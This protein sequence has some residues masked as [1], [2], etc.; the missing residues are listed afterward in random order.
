MIHQVIH[1]VILSKKYTNYAIYI[2]ILIHIEEKLKKYK[3]TVFK[4]KYQI[5]TNMLGNLY[6]GLNLNLDHPSQEF[7]DICIKKNDIDW[8]IVDN[9]L[10]QQLDFFV[11]ENYIHKK[12]LFESYKWDYD[13]ICLDIYKK[14]GLFDSLK[15]IGTRENDIIDQ[16]KKIFKKQLMTENDIINILLRYKDIHFTE[17][18][19]FKY[20]NFICYFD[21][22][23]STSI[24]KHIIKEYIF[25]KK[26]YLIKYIYEFDIVNEIFVEMLGGDYICSYNKSILLIKYVNSELIDFH[27]N[28]MIID[29]SEDICSLECDPSHGWSESN[30]ESLL[31]PNYITHLSLGWRYNMPINIPNSIKYFRTGCGFSQKIEIPDSVKYI[32]INGNYNNP[33]YFPDSVEYIVFSWNIC[34]SHDIILPKNI[35][36]LVYSG[37]NSSD[38]YSTIF[39]PNNIKELHI[40]NCYNNDIFQC[41]LCD[42]M[43]YGCSYNG[44]LVDIENSINKENEKN[45][46]KDIIHLIINKKSEIILPNENIKVYYDDILINITKKHAQIK[47]KNMQN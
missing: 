15:E 33:T 32:N 6:H 43:L 11:L 44:K 24:I 31:I 5:K 10:K 38:I 30:V 23:D 40:S 17:D 37:M 26:E 7:L 9:L 18:N 42:Y 3:Y 4:M 28:R 35:K 25:E 2:Y 14:F 41:R 27:H 45:K 16:F 12:K 8:I 21:Y 20:I 13:N 1:Q 19:V 29:K 22:N 34:M 46:N 39:I 47:I 36:Y